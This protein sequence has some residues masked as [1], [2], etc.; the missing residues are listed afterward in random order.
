MAAPAPIHTLPMAAFNLNRLYSLESSAR[1]STPSSLTEHSGFFSSCA[2]PD[3]G[4]P[5]TCDSEHGNDF[6]PPSNKS[7]CS[8][9]AG[10]EGDF[11]PLQICHK[12]ARASVPIPVGAFGEA[13]ILRD[14][15]LETMV[16]VETLESSSDQI[17]PIEL[18][19]QFLE[20]C[21][22]V[23]RPA[24]P[25]ARSVLDYFEFEYLSSRN[26]HTLV[27]G[28]QINDAAKLALLRAFY[29]A[30]E[31]IPRLLQRPTTSALLMAADEGSVCLYA[32]FGGQ[33]IT[34]TY[35]EELRQLNNTYDGFL[36]QLITSSAKHLD[37]LSR[38]PTGDDET[39]PHRP[40]IS[41][42]EWLRRPNTAP[43]DMTTPSISFPLIGLVQLSRFAVVCH[44]LGLTPG[45]YLASFRG[46]SG[47][48]QGVITAAAIASSDSW[49]SFYSNA[50]VALKILYSIGLRAHEASSSE[51]VDPNTVSDSLANDEG[52]PSSMLS[53]RGLGQTQLQKSVDELNSHLP[54]HARV[55]M[56]LANGRDNFVYAGPPSSL[57]ALG[58]KLRPLKTVS[59]VSETRTPF[60]KRKR[61]FSSQFLSIGAPFHSSHLDAAVEK[62][63]CDLDGVVMH[64]DKLLIPVYDTF[65]GLDLRQR[66]QGNQN[67]V[68]ALV[69]MVC[70][71]RV[72]WEKST[73]FPGCTHV[74][75]FG[76]GGNSG[77][78]SLT[79]NNKQG[80]GVRIIMAGSL[81]STDPEI[82][83]MIEIFNSSGPITYN[84]D[85]AASYQA[86][87]VRTSAQETFVNTRLSRLLSL[88]P[89]IIGGMTPTTKHVDFVS[90]AM[91]AG[92]HVEL[93]GGGYHDE[94]TMDAALRKL[95]DECPPGRGIT[96]NLLYLNPRALAWQIRLVRR[97]RS[98][99]I[100]IDG[101]TIGAGV[102]GP[103]IVAEYIGLGIRHISFKPGSEEA[104]N[105]VLD[106]A[107][108][109]PGFPVILQWT[110]GRGG[111]HHSCEDF[112][113]PILRAYS[114]IR[115]LPNI[116]LVAGSGFGDPSGSDTLPYLDGS[117]S[118]AFGHAPMPFDGILYGS[119]MMVALEAHTSLEAKTAIAAARG[120]QD[121]QWEGTMSSRSGAGSILSVTSEMG[122]PI[123][124]IATRGAQLW[125]EL[126]RDIF[127]KPRDQRVPALMNKKKY[128][129]DRLNRDFQKVWFGINQDGPTDLGNMTYLE[130]TS[131]LIQLVYCPYKEGGHN[132]VDPSYLALVS[133]FCRRLVSRFLGSRNQ[134]AA[135][136]NDYQTL[137]NR[138]LEYLSKLSD[139]CPEAGRRLLSVE[140]IEYFLS[141]CLQPGQK[142]VPFIPVLDDNFETYFKKDSLWQSENLEALIDGDVGRTFI[143]HGPVAAAFSTPDSINRPIRE[144]LHDINA[145]MIDGTFK[146]AYE[147]NTAQVPAIESFGGAIELP[148]AQIPPGVVSTRD[149]KGI[150]Y[151]I[152]P[153]PDIEPPPIE[154]WCQF[155]AGTERSWRYALLTTESVVSGN[156]RIVPNAIRR[157]LK[158]VSGFTFKVSSP[159]SP[160]R[161]KIS[162][163]DRQNDL[164]AEV[165]LESPVSKIIVVR[166]FNR[167]TIT[168]RPACLNS[169]FEYHPEAGYA[170]IRECQDGKDDA[171]RTF[172]W[173]TWIGHATMPAANATASLEETAGTSFTGDRVTVTREMIQR[174]S[175][176]SGG[177]V[178]SA[179]QSGSLAVPLDLA[180]ILGWKA[181]VKP[182]CS[183][184][185]EGDLSR[186]VH[187][188]NRFKS[189]GPILRE[190]D[191]VASHSSI[192]SVLNQANGKVVEIKCII[193]REE[194]PVIEVTSRFFIRGKFRDHQRTFET[195]VLPTTQVHIKNASD[196]A[197]LSS[198]SFITLDQSVNLAL[199]IGLK[200]NFHLETFIRFQDENTISSIQTHG[201]IHAVTQD[202][203]K[204][205]GAV[206]SSSTD[207]QNSPVQ[208]Y[209]QRKGR[210]LGDAMPLENPI[211]LN[212]E[213]IILPVS[214][215]AETYARVSG[216]FNP[217]HAS[218]SFAAYCDLPG[219]IVQGM[220]TSAAVH[221][222]LNRW[223]GGKGRTHA[224]QASFVGTVL[225][226]DSIAV[227]LRH[228]AMLSGRKVIEIEATVAGTGD[229]VLTA[230]AE[231][232][233]PRAAYVFTGQGS[234]EVGMGMDL[235]ESSPAAREVWEKAD[236]YFASNF[237]FALSAIVRENPK[238]LTV[239]FRG[240]QGRAI[241]QNYMDMA[242]NSPDGTS[243]KVFAEIGKTTTSYTFRHPDGLLFAT[244]FAQ[245]ALTVFSKARFADLASRELVPADGSAL[246]AGHSLGE[247]AALSTMG[248]AMTVEEL[249]AI[250]WFRGLNMRLVVQ[251]DE[252]GRSPYAMVAVNPSKVRSGGGFTED[253]LHA[254]VQC[255]TSR[256]GEL[257]EV[258]NYNIANLQYVCAGTKRALALFVDVLEAAASRDVEAAVEECAAKLIA[259]QGLDSGALELRRTPF[260]V[261]LKGVDVPF[262][263]SFLRPGIDAYRAFLTATLSKRSVKPEKLIGHWVP[264]VTG[265]VFGVSRE[266]VEQV[267]QLTGSGVLSTLLKKWH[268]EADA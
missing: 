145:G 231:V 86:K 85:W 217:I 46:L 162:V 166:I 12:A 187:L 174:F 61:P 155:L 97:L 57:H 34:K 76:P 53:I 141:L 263:S 173:R 158:P 206:T 89:I 190:G 58:R 224:Y 119:S 88:P 65:K 33:G 55:Q 180:I 176:I 112:H 222:A 170:P 27:C 146:V 138:P 128:I 175:A 212:S 197:V 127:S 153:Y 227:K 261:P 125:A 11:L 189:L 81:K 152:L 154:V 110:G 218:E 133:D 14:Q 203:E 245:P 211:P 239:Y 26:V 117:W 114:R 237:G 51:T 64:S 142:P 95:A 159:N 205:I 264:N 74:I 223:Y 52:Q 214:R 161:T 68:P 132:W 16:E 192:V 98:E 126:D 183:G 3:L 254:V 184:A 137:Q 108:A 195:S 62:I 219:T 84:P 167:Q 120:V 96:V 118:E 107:R 262:H 168:G 131:R 215:V 20:F 140:D 82:G 104:I 144:M 179:D 25:V 178:A 163:F 13:S 18:V 5:A 21:L 252:E 32:V 29:A 91:R 101:L 2:S 41:V 150:T 135:S 193:T 28:L 253:D 213:P 160:E 78:G 210:V 191:G 42:L 259:L 196:A 207:A 260:A 185:I 229:V 63:C 130:V 248:E 244:E 216:D 90:A 247:Y 83:G 267:H 251:H 73:S 19:A 164:V 111:G 105:A 37:N 236:K 100:N 103:E 59:G 226:G 177:L 106:I 147:G 39:L 93:A 50:L 77:I 35:F 230:E 238:E 22:G 109:H 6:V 220:W 235:F 265:R 221:A 40:S 255:V 122:Q 44:A 48:S 75:D 121:H 249:A 71:Q 171:I 232:E 257:L 200:V 79:A 165:G 250:T 92:F 69:R 115:A 228:V 151:N 17:T 15:Y 246:F 54:K 8:G 258:V 136:L 60:S 156:H 139:L 266:D 148:P 199:F 242:L 149:P 66:N 202:G 94:A 4:T 182:L 208:S 234:Q 9:F 67:L 38:S 124:V 243:R 256:T 47:H 36:Y 7:S 172:Y 10:E 134:R 43:A 45:Q 24:Q 225:P 241:R 49:E 70:S 268:L 23:G 102:P 30:R 99:G 186:L 201:T 143:L 169:R 188:S 116:I 198:R 56:A 123:H 87:L 233:E 157:L 240:R 209:L 31:A 72:D 181:L 129:V 113:D 80:R 1:S 194:Q 204:A